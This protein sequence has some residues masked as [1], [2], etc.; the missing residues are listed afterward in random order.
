VLN[1]KNEVLIRVYSV[2]AVVLVVAVVIMTR[3]FQLTV[4]D[5]H[6][7]EAKA[8]SLYVKLVDVPSQRGNILADD[9]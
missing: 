4:T 5:A 1:V 8:D 3:L 9:G 6:K 7:W 2:A